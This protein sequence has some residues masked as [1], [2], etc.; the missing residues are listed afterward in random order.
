MSRRVTING[1]S[2]K[3]V[4]LCVFYWLYDRVPSH[5]ITVPPS[6]TLYKNVEY[7]RSAT[8]VSSYAYRILSSHTVSSTSSYL[9]ER[10]RYTYI[11]DSVL[12]VEYRKIESYKY[13]YV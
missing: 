8:V 2:D 11:Y 9:Y 12:S 10:K 1:S 7:W 4:S 5:V 6:N 3:D 13:D